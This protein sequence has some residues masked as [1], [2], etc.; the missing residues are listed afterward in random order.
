[1]RNKIFFPFTLLVRIKQARNDS[2]VVVCLDTTLI[3]PGSNPPISLC[4]RR[5]CNVITAGQ[6][7]KLAQLTTSLKSVAEDVFRHM[8]HHHIKPLK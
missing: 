7:S 1:M 3:D 6:F 2:T 8:Y 4:F 5:I